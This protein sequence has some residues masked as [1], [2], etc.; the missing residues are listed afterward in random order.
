[1]QAI[2]HKKT[3]TIATNEPML[4]TAT[5]GTSQRDGTLHVTMQARTTQACATAS[6]RAWGAAVQKGRQQVISG[7]Q[8]W[9]AHASRGRHGMPGSY[10]GRAAAAARALVPSH[11][12]ALWHSGCGPTKSLSKLTFKSAP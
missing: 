1:M 9:H 11:C 2:A 3:Q 10:T 6:W 5:S 8:S 7:T 4:T 12:V